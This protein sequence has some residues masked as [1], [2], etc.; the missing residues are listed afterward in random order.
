[1]LVREGILS[2]QPIKPALPPFSPSHG[3]GRV[4]TVSGMSIKEVMQRWCQ[5][6]DTQHVR[7]ALLPNMTTDAVVKRIAVCAGSGN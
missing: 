4:I 7:I 1:M 6:S 2:I 5:Y 3:M